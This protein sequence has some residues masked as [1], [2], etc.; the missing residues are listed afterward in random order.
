VCHHCSVG[1][2]RARREESMTSSGIV[3]W[4]AI[5]AT[6]GGVL[7]VVWGLLGRALPYAAGGP[8]YDGLLRL[9]AGLVLLAALLTLVGLVALDALQGGSYWNLGRAG[10][11]VAAV[12]LLAQALA[13]LVLLVGSEALQWLLAPV[14]SLAVVVGLALYGAATLR[15][16][17][18]ARWCGWA[19]IVVPLVA[20]FLNSKVFYGSVAL[21]GV[22]WVALG[23]VLW[24]QSGRPSERPPRVR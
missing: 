24:S 14:G 17:V 6:I 4:G 13:A 23:Y 7:W 20:S 11:Y 1:K 2:L 10:F 12:G 18:L 8:F 5:A 15:A 21:F 22:L 19:L 3:R 9:S 16:G